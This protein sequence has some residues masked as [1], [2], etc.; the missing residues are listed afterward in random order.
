MICNQIVSI[1]G[2]F[3]PNIAIYT[4]SVNCDI[5]TEVVIKIGH[6]TIASIYKFFWRWR[7]RRMSITYLLMPWLLVLARHALTAISSMI[8]CSCNQEKIT[9]LVYRNYWKSTCIVCLPKKKKEWKVSIPFQKSTK[10]LYIRNG[11]NHLNWATCLGH[12]YFEG[13][14]NT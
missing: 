9:I 7:R 14:R 12:K 13:S 6:I 10:I 11:V 2:S 3:I 4:C 1:Q 5:T 8:K